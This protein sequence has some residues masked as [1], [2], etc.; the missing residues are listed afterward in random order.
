MSGHSS[1]SLIPRKTFFGNAEALN[2]KLSPDGRW[3]A[4]I[5]AVDGVMNV[6]AAPRDDLTKARPLTRQTDRP[7]FTHWFARTNA[8]VLFLKDKDGDENFNLW[9][10]GTDGSDARN[11]TPYPDVL[12][13]VVGFHHE[14]P[15]L[16]AVSMNDRDAR[17]H[18]LYIVDIRTGERRLVY[19]N[20]TE[21]A[22]LPSRQPAGPQACHHHARQGARIGD[23]EMDRRRFRGDHVGRSR[24]RAGHLP[25]AGQPGR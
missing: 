13:H 21:I 3:L 2:P 10:V 15:N 19:E 12:A 8:H 16:I 22:R 18:D 11:L 25:D 24:R 1:I 14:D 23:L 6:W 20:T 5:A 4:W 17:W 9:C 7:I